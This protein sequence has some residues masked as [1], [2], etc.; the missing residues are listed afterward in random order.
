MISNISQNIESITKDVYL[1]TSPYLCKKEGEYS[2]DI[3][4]PK[5]YVKDKSIYTSVSN[6]LVLGI[7][8]ENFSKYNLSL[9]GGHPK[10]YTKIVKEFESVPQYSERLFV[11]TNSMANHRDLYGSVSWQIME[12]DGIAFKKGDKGRRLVFT[13]RMPFGYVHKHKIDIK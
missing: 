10:S 4:D 3:I 6:G 2:N 11:L 9:I 12:T 1:P 7:V 8:V 5:D 13:F